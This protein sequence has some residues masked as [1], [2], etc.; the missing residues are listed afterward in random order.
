VAG[1][2]RNRSRDLAYL[3]KIPVVQKRE[4]G[5]GE[6]WKAPSPS[7]QDFQTRFNLRLEEAR[8]RNP[9]LIETYQL[10]SKERE[11]EV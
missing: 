2:K 3:K 10:V 11:G 5:V 4:Y 1:N 6:I 7:P 9:Q 8:G